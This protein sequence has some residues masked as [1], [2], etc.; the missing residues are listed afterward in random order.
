METYQ[1]EGIISCT[2]NVIWREKNKVMN[3][4][5]KEQRNGDKEKDQNHEDT[6][7]ASQNRDIIFH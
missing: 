7:G 2:H 6:R 4:R 5:K 3:T 1:T